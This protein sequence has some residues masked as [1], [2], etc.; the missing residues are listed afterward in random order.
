[1]TTSLTNEISVVVDA[2]DERDSY[3]PSTPVSTAILA[4]SI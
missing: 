4:S 1:M 2:C 3:T